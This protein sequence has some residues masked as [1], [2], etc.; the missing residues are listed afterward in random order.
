MTSRRRPTIPPTAPSPT[1]P[2][3]AAPLTAASPAAD[4]PAGSARPRPARAAAA[5]SAAATPTTTRPD[6]GRRAEALPG[7][8]PSA[9]GPLAADLSAAHPHAPTT[10]GALSARVRLARHRSVLPLG[11]SARVVGLDPDSALVVEGLPPPLAALLDRLDRPAYTTELVAEAHGVPAAVTR[12][13]LAQLVDAGALVDA[14]TTDR[15]A[16]ARAGGVVSVRGRGPLAV[17]VVTGLLHSGIG[18][19]HTDTGGTVR[20]A[21]LGTGYGDT[22]VG[23]A[24]LRATQAAVRRLLPSAVTRAPPLRFRPDLVVL[25]DESPDPA[26][27]GELRARGL[28]HLAVRLR[29]GVGIVGPLV[30]PGRTACLGCLDLARGDLDPRWPAVA[31]QLAGRAGVADPAA[32]TA[33]VGLAVAQ[34]V[35]AIEGGHIPAL[36]AT[37]E[38]E[39]DAGGLRRRTWSAHPDCPCGA[40]RAPVDRASQPGGD[41]IMR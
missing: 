30:Y 25:A 7:A 41:T 39:V 16:L 2:S 27:V 18:T 14:D 15:A 20:G 19:V 1:A 40:G 5:R 31:A 35:A 12:H 26:T 24:R 21:D 3:P 37:L 23:Q 11:A 17:G 32:A 33:T 28:A 4:A 36:S 9:S 34:V 10:R 29:D 22:D 13:L 38:L 6:A 8:S